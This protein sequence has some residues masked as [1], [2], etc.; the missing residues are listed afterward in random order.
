VLQ[1]HVQPGASRTEVA[2]L[3][4]DCLKIRLAA[5]AVDGEANACLVEFLAGALGVAKRAVSIDSGAA[6]R[7]KRVAVQAP[8]L[9]PEALWKE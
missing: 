6:S 7:R 8:A 4:G 1:V 3:H 2:G 5:R 9:G